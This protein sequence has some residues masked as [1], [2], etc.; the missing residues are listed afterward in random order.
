[1]KIEAETKEKPFFFF[2]FDFAVKGK[3]SPGATAIASVTVV[4]LRAIQC[5][6]V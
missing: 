5:F 6:A 3:L 2:F 4:L 1:M